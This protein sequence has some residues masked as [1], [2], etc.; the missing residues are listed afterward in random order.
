MSMM[1]TAKAMDLQVGN[2]IRKL[3]LLKL[4]DQAND[5]GECWPSYASIAK[6]AEC[7]RTSVIAHI[8]WL[9]KQG[10]LWVERRAIGKGQNLT[11]VYHLT[12]ENGGSNAE[13]GG[14][15]A[16]LGGGSNAEPKPVNKNQSMNQS[17]NHSNAHAEACAAE[18]DGKPSEKLAKT[19]KPKATKKGDSMEA[20]LA[21]L[22][23]LGV[24]SQTAKDWLITRKEKRAGSLTQT[25]LAA[26][27]R[28]AG[29]AGLTAAQAVQ[30]AAERNW[31]RFVASYVQNE[32]QGFVGAPACPT[33]RINDVPN[34][35]GGGVYLA[36]DLI[37]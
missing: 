6:A 9:E 30:V 5:K 10:F 22:E 24:D 27:Q 25:V 11:N 28:E 37:P 4:A 1:L 32:T 7:G 15:N 35:T 34:H 8:D 14:S 33:N 23:S 17:M 18:P 3:V 31:A 36:K 26:L 13:L 20:D 12:L 2:P 16:E 21:A 29:K 19:A